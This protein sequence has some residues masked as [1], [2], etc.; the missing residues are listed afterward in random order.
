MKYFGKGGVPR[1]EKELPAPAPKAFGSHFVSSDGEPTVFIEHEQKEN[2]ATDNTTLTPS[3]TISCSDDTTMLLS[4]PLSSLLE[5]GHGMDQL[6][7]EPATTVLLTDTRQQEQQQD[8]TWIDTTA[9][10]TAFDTEA[11]KMALLLDDDDDNDQDVASLVMVPSDSQQQKVRSKSL[12]AHALL[13]HEASLM[14]DSTVDFDLYRRLN[15][16]DTDLCDGESPGALRLTEEGL[17]RHERKTMDIQQNGE[18]V[19]SSS[20]RG[21]STIR[22]ARAQKQAAKTSKRGILG[23]S[24]DSVH[25][26]MDYK[27]ELRIE[28]LRQKEIER[29][30]KREA[31][32]KRVLPSKILHIDESS[33]ARDTGIEVM[34]EPM[35]TSRNKKPREEE[36][37]DHAKLSTSVKAFTCIVCSSR[38][39]THIAVPCMHFSFCE[40]C[41]KILRKNQWACPV[42]GTP[43]T[44]YNQVFA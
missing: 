4:S 17:K 21:L 28:K 14:D 36:T 7:L 40:P 41:A 13:D 32:A 20:K 42:C 11:I 18:Y 2:A 25:Q 24:L 3:P 9:V 31:Q 19:S 1:Q 10:C 12:P 29:Q 15:K 44:T 37:S 34:N 33:V 8:T 5:C 43:H 6:T 26:F 22:L 35:L 38:E 30:R 39:R 16:S 23:K 27:E